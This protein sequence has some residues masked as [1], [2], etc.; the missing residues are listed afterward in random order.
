MFGTNSFMTIWGVVDKGNYAEV[1]L[2]SSKKN[3]LTGNNEQDFG[4]KFVRFVGDAYLQRPMPEQRIKLTG[5]GVQNAYVKDGKTQYLKNPVYVVWGYELQEGFEKKASDNG[6][7]DY[8]KS[9][10]EACDDEEQIPF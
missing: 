10:L 3:K 1:S 4:C 7:S 2:S 8:R 5:C 6:G 9:L